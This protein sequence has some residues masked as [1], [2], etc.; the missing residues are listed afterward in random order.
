MLLLLNAN[1]GNDC[2]LLKTDR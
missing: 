1:E 2:L